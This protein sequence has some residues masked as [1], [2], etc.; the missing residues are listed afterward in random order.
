[1]R[2]ALAS[3]ECQCAIL[4]CCGG[5]RGALPCGSRG[6][7]GISGESFTNVPRKI[8]VSSA[9]WACSRRSIFISGRSRGLLCPWWIGR[10]PRSILGFGSRQW[11]RQLSIP[12][13]FRGPKIVNSVSYRRQRGIRR[14][15]HTPSHTPRDLARARHG[16]SDNDGVIWFSPTANDS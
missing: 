9:T 13:R 15:R 14:G 1:M 6:R 3:L 4:P 8:P 5:S 7:F 12:A 11:S 16:I 10:S 2:H